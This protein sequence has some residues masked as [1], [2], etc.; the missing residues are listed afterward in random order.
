MFRKIRL[1]VCVMFLLVAWEL[2]LRPF[3]NN[4]INAQSTPPIAAK[5]N[6]E[7]ARLYT[8]DQSDREPKE[9]QSINWA[10]VGPRDKKRLERVREMYQGD[11]LA[12][13]PDYYYSA[14]ILQ[15]SSTATD[16][17]LAHELCV[18]AISMGESRTKWLAA[19]SEDRFL[20][21]IGR[22]QRFGT[23]YKSNGPNT[24]FL[25]GK[26]EDGVTDNLRRAFNAPTLEGAKA[27]E[28]EM[29]K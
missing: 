19:A 14:M 3:F 2:G 9:G 22:S 28:K 8:E 26:I 12:T 27:R 23:Q 18:V 15:H 6:E 17:L 24:P 10:L 16:Y 5:D 7:L 21:S 11:K 4:S 29:N 13:G 25:L 20:Q 1:I